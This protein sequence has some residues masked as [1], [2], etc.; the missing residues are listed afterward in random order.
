MGKHLFTL[1][2]LICRFPDLCS[3]VPEQSLCCPLSYSPQLILETSDLTSVGTVLP[4][5]H[6]HGKCSGFF[7]LEK[8][9]QG[10]SR[11]LCESTDHPLFGQVMFCCVSGHSVYIQTPVEAHLGCFQFGE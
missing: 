2:H 9:T 11:L 5:G 6:I 1:Y 3:P 7:H 8:F 10:L 4:E